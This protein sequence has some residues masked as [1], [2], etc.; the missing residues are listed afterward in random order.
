MA[1]KAH[2]T[3]KGSRQF[4]YIEANF[5]CIWHTYFLLTNYT[6]AICHFINTPDSNLSVASSFFMKEKMHSLIFQPNNTER[7]GT[8]DLF[9][10]NLSP[11]KNHLSHI[12]SRLSQV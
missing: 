2:N 3:R 6:L 12:E 1:V 4:V 7:L 9:N 8:C 11:F 10:A 5:Q